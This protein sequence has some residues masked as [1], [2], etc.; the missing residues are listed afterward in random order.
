MSD[1]YPYYTNIHP[2][3]IFLFGGLLG[4]IFGHI[5]P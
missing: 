3:W 4:F 1:E 5:F 2:L